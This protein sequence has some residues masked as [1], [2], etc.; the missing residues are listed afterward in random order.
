MKAAY[1]D[2]YGPPEVVKWFREGGD[3][4]YWWALDGAASP[5]PSAAS[6]SP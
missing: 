1:A 4:S 6:L 3:A 5:E 2:R